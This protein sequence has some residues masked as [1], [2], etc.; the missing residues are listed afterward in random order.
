MDGDKQ[1]ETTALSGIRSNPL[2]ETLVRRRSRFVACLTAVTIIPWC[3]YILVAG[4]APD[5]LAIRFSELS[6][7]NI[8]WPI[9]VLMIVGTW[10]LTGLY[11][12]RA[13]GEFDELTEKILAGEKQ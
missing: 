8:G 10:C 3:A 5:V 2:F 9:A 6:I 12:F 13:N 1:M 4:F 7:I 11:L